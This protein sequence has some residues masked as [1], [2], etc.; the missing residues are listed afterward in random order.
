MT[1]IDV[2]KIVGR[3]DES[4]WAQ[5][6]D[7]SPEDEQKF[8]VRGRLLATITLSKKEGESEVEVVSHGREI[9][10]HLHELYFGQT[11][12]T[13]IE[14]L[15]FSVA[16]LVEEDPTLQI[17]C[18]VILNDN[19]YLVSVGG[20]IWIREGNREGFLISPQTNGE[21]EKLHGKLKPNMQIVLGNR[22]FWQHIPTGVIRASLESGVEQAMETL[23]AVAHGSQRAQGVAGIIIGVRVETEK[24][25]FVVSH[26][27]VTEEIP[28]VSKF[29][30]LAQKLPK[31]AGPVYVQYGVNKTSRTLVFGI[32]FLISFAVL[33]IA[34]R[35][36]YQYLVSGRAKLDQR[37][38]ELAFKFNEAKA[39][40]V[41]NPT[42]SRQ[43]LPEIKTELEDIQFKGGSKYKNSNLETV[44]RELPATL[45][46]S[47]GLNRAELTEV[48]D[49]RLVRDGMIG[50]KMGWFE[51]KLL[52]LD[53]NAS[54]LVLV[55]PI[56]KS[57]TVLLGGDVIAGA[58]LVASYPGKTEILA[59]KGIIELQNS[60]SKLQIVSDKD[61][62]TTIDM[63]M[64]AGNIY[65]LTNNAIWRYQTTET[66]FGTKQSWI[67]KT[68]SV[69]LNGS[70]SLTIDG[71]LWIAKS[72]EIIKLTRGV[73]ENFAISDLT[74]PLGGNLIIY[75]NEDA[76]KLYILDKINKRL[77]VLNK[78][79]EYVAQY[80]NDLIP[81]VSSLVADEKNSKV[82]LLSA[83]KIWQIDL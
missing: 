60:K 72:S 11:E 48:L 6:H 57:G 38:E 39:L 53:T 23:G 47:M 34:G 8:L 54:R 41:L 77:V 19:L 12:K 17:S 33:A 4:F 76:E 36:R 14:Q 64:Y 5:V 62:G 73:K 63:G 44:A 21:I 31:R 58:R 68:E 51:G 55:D 82:Y 46:K 30:W 75:T 42:R 65:L 26:E 67:A 35:A 79:G 13:V 27:E 40:V 74:I 43:L 18:A 81:G 37:S 15:N 50:T 61:W 25:K 56:K 66:G 3:V 16:S 78:T 45:D 1:N 28:T 71:S 70:T 9:L 20:G 22:Q 32:I 83:S 69:D 49:L 59:D 80:T 24:P 10:S 52:V 29:D 2:A 7:F